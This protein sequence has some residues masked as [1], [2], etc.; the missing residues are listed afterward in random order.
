MKKDK[1]KKHSIHFAV[2]FFL[3]IALLTYLS[4]TIDTMLLPKVKTT[5]I[6]SG[7]LV[8]TTNPNEDKYLVP[9][10][11]ISGF[12]EDACVFVV[13]QYNEKGDNKVRSESV[14]ITNQDEMYCEVTADNLYAGMKIV[15]NT[16]KSI[17]NGDRVYVEEE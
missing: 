17:N 12:G 7:A 14:Y 15:Y 16:S 13:Q 4:D 10:S 5:E 8:E 2:I 11:A 1:L 9:L 3:V 6:I